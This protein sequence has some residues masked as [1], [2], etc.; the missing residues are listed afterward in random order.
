M[1]DEHRPAAAVQEQLD[2]LP[3]TPGV[4]IF[5]N[6]KNKV[7]YVGKATSL[8]Q[9]VRSY[10]Q[11]ASNDQR[12]FIARLEKELER[13]EFNVVNTESEAAILENSLI[14][15]HK[16]L[17][18]VRLR[19]DKEFLSIRLD[20]KAEWPRLEVRR[21][22]KADHAWYFGPYA[23]G[24]AVRRT[25]NLVNKHFQLRT[26][27]DGEFKNRIRPCLQY[28]IKRCPGP[29]V[30]PVERR[31]YMHQVD[32]VKAFLE[33][34][35]DT[36]IN[37]LRKDMARASHDLEFERA[38]AL[39][40]QIEALEHV[41]EKQTVQST[42]KLNQDV[43]AL[44]RQDD[45]GFIVVAIVRQGRTV[46]LQHFPLTQLSAPNDEVISGFI[47]QYYEHAMVPNEV[48][49]AQPIEAMP[50]VAAWLEQKA[51]KRVEIAVPQ[52]GTR[53]KLLKLAEQNAEHG[54]RA[55]W[56]TQS[57][58]ERELVELQEILQLSEV[59]RRIE[60]IDIS[61]HG[62]KHSVAAVV[63][64]KNGEPDKK[65]YRTYRLR[66]SGG[67][68]YA[69]MYEVLS[70]R[71]KR[72]KENEKGWQLPDLLVVDGGKGQLNQ[73]LSALR[74]LEI[75]NVPVVG[76]AKERRNIQDEKLV[77]RVFLPGQ[78]NPIE[79][80]SKRRCLRFLA[81]ARDEAHRFSNS[82]RKKQTQKT[83]FLNR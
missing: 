53:V 81:V 10:F 67:D 79:L 20:A 4:Y 16:P 38:L 71:L 49:L 57:Q 58:R 33:G 9:R 12:Y 61:H 65:G 47:T 1:S 21:K 54:F 68:D 52:R 13:I 64:L 42:H 82:F 19:D 50:G 45:L 29:C 39:R 60:C 44:Y 77:D 34:R 51:A 37:T 70:R 31:D 48:I 22:P 69:A 2:A 11:P 62:G 23:S 75:E 3:D 46:D 41:L 32:L 72:G 63:A 76:L 26:C 25:L 15:Q 5:R 18:N 14:K 28:Q 43:I 36:L 27:T 78:S 80:S 73:A 66:T 30:L 7:L 35:H 17:Y 56:D 6:A 8:R 24:T 74:D 40:D 83:V 59:P 55:H